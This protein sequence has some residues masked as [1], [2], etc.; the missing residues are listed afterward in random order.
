[1]ANP[2]Q[3]QLIEAVQASWLSDTAYRPEEWSVDNPARGQCVV[4]SLVVQDYFYGDLKRYRVRGW[5]INETHYVNLLPD[6]TEL[7][8]TASQYNSPVE[9]IEK[10]FTPVDYRTLREKCLADD[11][12]FRRY[13]IFAR[14][15]IG[16]L[17]Q[18]SQA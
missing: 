8:T 15:V 12:T 7:D 2:T 6:G 3:E 13:K 16:K 5:G 10:P 4:S 17:A 14:R 1:M 9:F 11:D 18:Q